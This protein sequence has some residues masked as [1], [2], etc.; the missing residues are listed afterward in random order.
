[1]ELRIATADLVLEPLTVAHADA[2]FE[3]LSDPLIY[4]HLDHGPPPSLEHLRGVYARLQT[5]L[6]PDGRQAWLNWIV[7]L[8]GGEPVGCV[9]A[10][11]IA[12]DTTWIAYQ[13]ASRHWGRGYARAATEAMLSHLRRDWGVLRFLA[14]AESANMRSIHLLDR[15]G[16]R[17]ATAAEAAPH[18]LSATERLFVLVDE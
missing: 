1:M 8:A 18:S 2:M 12:P 13:L 16:F 5:R 7:R 6:S 4:H 17:T 3:L 11:V 9:Q 15:L 14:V 10:T